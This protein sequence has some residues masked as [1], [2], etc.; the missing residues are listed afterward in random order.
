MLVWLIALMLF[1]GR[2]LIVIFLTSSNPSY[3][4]I[5]LIRSEVPFNSCL[6]SVLL[7]LADLTVSVAKKSRGC[8]VL[9]PA[10]NFEAS[11]K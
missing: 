3:S 4:S 5:L 7:I 1:G 9:L 8:F 10:M 11:R 6:I 2:S